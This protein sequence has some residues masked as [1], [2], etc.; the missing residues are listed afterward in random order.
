MR[1]G[2]NE[3]E[4]SFNYCNKLLGELRYQKDI[5]TELSSKDLQKAIDDVK[6]NFEEQYNWQDSDVWEA[7]EDKG[8]IKEIGTRMDAEYEVIL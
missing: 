7:L 3:K 2:K 1:E 6:D 8:L 4:K 5:E